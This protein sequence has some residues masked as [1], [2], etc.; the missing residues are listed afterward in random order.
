MVAEGFVIWVTGYLLGIIFR[1]RW[2]DH[3]REKFVFCLTDLGGW[4]LEIWIVV[5]APVT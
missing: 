5:S 4:F 1:M 2:I 3:G